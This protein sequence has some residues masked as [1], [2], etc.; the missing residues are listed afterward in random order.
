MLVK[1]SSAKVHQDL[2]TTL[3]EHSDF[4]A[5]EF[6]GCGLTLAHAIERNAELHE[7]FLL[8]VLCVA[9]NV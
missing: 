4:S 2:G 6:D 1:L 7:A 3:T 5:G 8:F 9:L